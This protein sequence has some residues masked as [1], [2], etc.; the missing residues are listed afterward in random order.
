MIAS[1]T[2]VRMSTSPAARAGAE[3]GG[4]FPAARDALLDLT[5][6]DTALLVDTAPLDTAPLDTAPLDAVGRADAVVAAVDEAGADVEARGGCDDGSSAAGSPVHPAPVA[7][8]AS[9]ASARRR[10]LIIGHILPAGRRVGN[11]TPRKLPRPGSP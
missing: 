8:T 5:G 9:N 7:T 10:N 6:R 4:T 1:A 2:T 11:R 3:R